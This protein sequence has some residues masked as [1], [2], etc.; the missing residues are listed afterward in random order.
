VEL[1]RRPIC[2]SAWPASQGGDG[3][4]AFVLRCPVPGGTAGLV[5][6]VAVAEVTAVSVSLQPTPAPPGQ[7]A[8]S[9]S[10]TRPA[11]EQSTSAFAA[12]MP[13]PSGFPCGPGSV[14]VSG[15]GRGFRTTAV[16]LYLP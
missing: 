13:V 15:E 8:W 3:P 9:G 10:V 12:M 14:R 5:H 7:R 11:T 16:P 2:T 6:V 4:A 1:D